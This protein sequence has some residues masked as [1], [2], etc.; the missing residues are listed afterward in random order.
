MKL[1]RIDRTQQPIRISR[2]NFFP[3]EESTITKLIND[4]INNLGPHKLDGLIFQPINEVIIIFK[5]LK[6]FVFVFIFFL[7]L[8]SLVPVSRSLNGNVLSRIPLIT[9]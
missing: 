3:I 6:I 9:N 4:D 7:S 5:Y 8:T 1:G 2:K